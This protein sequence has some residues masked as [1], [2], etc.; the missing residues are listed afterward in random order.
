MLSNLSTA[1]KSRTMLKT[2]GK[3]KVTMKIRQLV[4]HWK[5]TITNDSPKTSLQVQI[6]IHDAARLAALADLFPALRY[7]EVVAELLHSAL[8][9]AQEAFPYVQ[10]VKQTGEDEFGN[11]IYAD[12]G[13]T[14]KFL[15][16]MKTHLAR[17]EKER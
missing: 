3:R 11:P 5:N 13:Y 16:L 15:A 9:E 10:G 2:N 4:N 14:P 1:N 17:L 7:D 12:D 6:P 8:D